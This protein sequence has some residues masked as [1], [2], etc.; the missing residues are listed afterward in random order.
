M[1]DK[2]A[3][4]YDRIS[5]KI[6]CT[7]PKFEDVM[8]SIGDFKKVPEWITAADKAVGGRQPTTFAA[9]RFSQIME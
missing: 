2:L 3:R 5:A 4:D 8:K 1:H 9:V 7:I 6:L